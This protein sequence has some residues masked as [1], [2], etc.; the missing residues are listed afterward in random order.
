MVE[1]CGITQRKWARKVGSEVNNE[2]GTIFVRSLFEPP[3]PL[4][5]FLKSEPRSCRGEGANDLQKL[6]DTTVVGH[7]AGRNRLRL[8]TLGQTIWEQKD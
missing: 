7:F 5:R 1:S 4:S 8:H 2:R 3:P 6:L